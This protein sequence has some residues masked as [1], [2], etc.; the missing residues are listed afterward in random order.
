MSKT[1]EQTKV[2][3]CPYCG[4]LVV[5]SGIARQAGGDKQ[6]YY[7][8]PCDRVTLKPLE[9]VKLPPLPPILEIKPKPKKV[10]SAVKVSLS[11]KAGVSYEPCA[12]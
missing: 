6:R 12:E 5:K 9:T 2:L 4:G 1:T 8:R 7:C 3:Y 11:D 10:K